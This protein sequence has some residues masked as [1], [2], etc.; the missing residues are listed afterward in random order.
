MH[1]LLCSVL[2]QQAFVS[3]RSNETEYI[4]GVLDG[5]RESRQIEQHIQPK[6]LLG[7]SVESN[8]DLV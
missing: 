1:R 7:T 8:A 6:T 3:L 2:Y 5:L 4:L